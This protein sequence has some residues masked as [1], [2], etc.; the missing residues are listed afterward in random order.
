MC[1]WSTIPREKGQLKQLSPKFSVFSD[2]RL[3]WP[4]FPESKLTLIVVCV[5]KEAFVFLCFILTPPRWDYFRKLRGVTSDPSFRLVVLLL[6]SFFCLSSGPT[7]DTSFVYVVLWL[8]WSGPEQAWRIFCFCLNPETGALILLP[9]IKR[10]FYSSVSFFT[11]FS[12][13]LTEAAVQYKIAV[14]ITFSSRIAP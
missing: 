3:F 13:I 8:R 12:W 5:L 10:S 2:V 4:K 11:I 1:K 7:V 9:T 14:W 6:S